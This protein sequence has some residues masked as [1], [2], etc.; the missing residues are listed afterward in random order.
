MM[1]ADGAVRRKNCADTCG[2][3]NAT[4]CFV[5]P[6][7]I[8][9]I[10]SLIDQM[11]QKVSFDSPCRK[12]LEAA[13]KW[14]Q[15]AGSL[16]PSAPYPKITCNKADCVGSNPYYIPGS[17]SISMCKWLFAYAE[18]AGAQS[19]LHEFLHD[20]G[21]GD[22]TPAQTSILTACFPGFVP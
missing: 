3:D 22:G 21:V 2:P 7:K 11:K 6:Q 14:H 16:M 19:M 17:R 1:A 13:G 20:A 4:S 10:K 5:K 12:A 15:V 18:P 9:C 8:N